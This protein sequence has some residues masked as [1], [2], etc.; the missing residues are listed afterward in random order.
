VNAFWLVLSSAL[1]FSLSGCKKDTSNTIVFALSADYPPF[2]FMDH[3]A[4]KGFDVELAK[5][6]AHEIKKEAQFQDMQ[7]S[8]VLA[9]LHSR[10]VDA[11]IST[12]A[13]TPER[14]KHFDFSDS[15]HED[16]LFLL[17]PKD[18]IFHHQ[19]DLKNKKI[20]CQLGTTMDVWLKEHT[21]HTV[22]IR[23]KTTSQ[24]VEDLKA[25]HVDGVLIDSAQAVTFARQNPH[26]AH[27]FIAKSDHGYGIALPKGSPLKPAINRALGVLKANGKLDQLKAKWFENAQ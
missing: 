22:I 1:V 7:F 13:I 5:M 2:E 12:I 4:I 15:Y 9:A 26:L 6:I 25:G 3:D 24:A 23:T 18:R 8:S 21:D 17:H 11:A 16:S 14:Q 19:D 10:S 27:T 20:A